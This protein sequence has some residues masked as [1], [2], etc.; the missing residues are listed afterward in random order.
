[1]ANQNGLRLLTRIATLYYTEGMKQ[2]EIARVLNLSQS[3]VSRALNR[4]VKEEDPVISMTLAQL[5]ACTRVV[6]L[7]GSMQKVPAIWAALKGGLIDVLITDR[8]TAV[9]LAQ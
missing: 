9:E 2:T 3:Q 7:A 4:C 6:A 5:K 8:I 1:M